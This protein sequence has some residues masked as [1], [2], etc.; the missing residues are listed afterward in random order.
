MSKLKKLSLTSWILLSLVAGIVFGIVINL[1]MASGVDA[2]FKSM[3]DAYLINGVF[4]LFGQIFIKSIKMLVV[5]LVLISLICGVTGI[6]DMSKL[7]RVG[8]KA[9]V[10]YLSTTA[11]AIT[12]A[13]LIAQIIDPGEGITIPTNTDNFSAGEA[14]GILEVLLNI[15]PSN[16]FESMMKG[17]MLQVIFFALLVGISI[18]SLGKRALTLLKFFD[19]LNEVV[20]KMVTIVMLVAPIGVFCLVANVTAKLGFDILINLFIYILTVLLVLLVHFFVT[21]GGIFTVFTRLNF[22]TFIKKMYSAM[23]V[24]FS[25]SSS[26]ATI[27]VTM[28]ALTNKMGAS[29]GVSSFTVPFGATINMDGTAIM[30]GVAVVFISQIY[31][32]DISLT[33]YLMVILTATLASIGTAGVPGVGMITLSMVLVQAGLPVEAISIIFGIDRILD[34]SR[35][36]VN[37][38]GDATATM[39]IAKSEGELNE[40]IFNDPN[41]DADL[42]PD[43]VWE[44]IEEKV[45]ETHEFYEKK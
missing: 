28:T 21:Y 18:A 17:E 33:G 15:I 2:S 5:P 44:D 20:M 37:V 4:E 31:G 36:V 41:A 39:V 13:L 27:P 38:C 19:E 10:F 32:I 30:Q 45:H 26:N 6:G 3:I 8:G 42:D 35:T 9:L 7:G 16:P 11:V 40:D 14:P 24:A 23:L 43:S 12:F 34:M 29:K 25:T 1:I 22:F